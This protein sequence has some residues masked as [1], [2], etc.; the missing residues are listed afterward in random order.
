MPY[1]EPNQNASRRQHHNR[2]RRAGGR[3][4]DWE[5]GPGRIVGRPG[6]RGPRRG[7]KGGD[8][9]AATL[10]LLDKAPSHGYGLIQQIAE[11]SG[12]TWAP[13][14]GSIYPVLQQLEDEGL[15]G[16]ERI[17]GRKTA[18]LTDAGRKYL[19]ENRE[20][21]GDP[22]KVDSA[23][24]NRDTDE[25]SNLAAAAKSMNSAAKQVMADGTE[26]QQLKAAEM[27]AETRRKLYA[28]LAEDDT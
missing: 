21:L 19:T 4:F 24:R 23:T 28:L 27:I 16:F 7:K 20:A 9:R 11:L 13:S 8:V 18:T 26:A 14:P 1:Q 12:G 15:I 10:I 25:S 3:E 5:T 22:W 17:E 6:P 2:A